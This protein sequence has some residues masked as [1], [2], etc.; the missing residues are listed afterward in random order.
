ME[1][2][3]L[4]SVVTPFHN[5]RST[6]PSVSRASCAKLIT[7]WEY[8]LVDNCS[9]DGS[10]EIASQYAA[11][12]PDKIRLICTPIHFFLRSKTTI[13]PFL[14]FLPTA[15]IARWCR[16]TIGSFPIA[17]RAWWKWL[18]RIQASALSPP[19]NWSL[20]TPLSV[21]CPIP[22]RR[23]R[24]GTSV[25]LFSS[26]I[27]YFFG[28]PTCLLMRSELVRSRKPFYEER[29]APFEDAH[30]CF[31]ALRTW[32][33][34][35]V[36]QVLT[37]SRRNNDRFLARISRFEF[38][39]FT[40]LEEIVVHGRDYLSED[41]YRKCLKEAERRVFLLSRGVCLTWQGSG[42]LEDSP[43]ALGHDQLLS[44]FRVYDQ[45]DS[46]R[47]VRSHRESKAYLGI[48]LAASQ[49]DFR[50]HTPGSSGPSIVLS[51]ESGF[52]KTSK[53]GGLG[54]K[55]SDRLHGDRKPDMLP[56][57][58][59]KNY[60]DAPIFSIIFRTLSKCSGGSA[61]TCFG[62]SGYHNG[63]RRFAGDLGGAEEEKYP[64]RF[65]SVPAAHLVTWSN[66]CRDLPGF[67]FG[68][69][70]CR[71]SGLGRFYLL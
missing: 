57:K 18:K 32:N 14:R 42:V 23:C 22:A 69:L 65:D 49:Q 43:R 2:I 26:E 19:T 12:F 48:S 1:S 59:Q 53:L 54:P 68:L 3:P 41:E 16:R 35:F 51:F 46:H 36:H 38:T 5:T 27:K 67:A 33:F 15:N 55:P 56:R 30:A 63:N 70:Y 31:D 58:I 29:Y 61:L 71:V 8:I 25:G 17:S 7:N 50:R 24:A 37:Y 47:S 28:T 60:L 62:R 6:L 39:R 4:V 34:G 52:L 21:A 40:R 66:P 44:Q 45:V 64:A 20:T 13:S 10:S 11:R 9:T